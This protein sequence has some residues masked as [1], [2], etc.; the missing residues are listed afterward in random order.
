MIVTTGMIIG[1]IIAVAG[2]LLTAAAMLWKFCFKIATFE[3][4]I[5]NMKENQLA[6]KDDLLHDIEK[7][8]DKDIVAML[9]EKMNSI[10][11]KLD[12]L[13]FNKE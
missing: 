1:G 6:M 5:K 12:Q 13:I 9:L 7:K 11:S 10:D 8:A 2:P 4:E 3:N